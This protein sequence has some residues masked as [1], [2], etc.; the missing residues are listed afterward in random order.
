MSVTFETAAS[1]VRDALTDA[2]RGLVEREAMVELVALSAVA[3]EHL[4]VIGPPGTAKSEAVRRTARALG[5][6]YFEYLLGRFTEPSE[7]FGPVDLRKL[8]E[9]LVETETSGMLPEAEVAF[10]DEVFLGSTAI[11]NTLL[12]IL[13]ERTFRRGHTRMRC[14][15]RVCVGA[16]NALP[17]DDSLAA[18]ADRFL[19]RIFVEPVPDPRLEELLAGGA[20]LWGEGEARATSLESLDVLA[21]VAREA[22][23]ASVRPHLAHALRSLRA[24]GIGLSDRRA[25]K[26]QKLIASAA[27]LAGRRVPSTADL[28]PLVYAV[29]TKEAQALA[30]DVLRELLSA[31]ENPAL[32]AA[33]LEASAGPLARAQRIASAGEVLLSERPAEGNAEALAAW[34]LKLEGVAREMD[35]GFAPESLPEALKAL[36]ARLSEVL[37]PGAPEAPANVA[38]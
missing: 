5:G 6:S 35:A 2:G 15:L 8:R 4:L 23:L 24:A 17:E 36:R 22:D 28:W 11:L 29:P 19:T 14:P 25:V 10:L 7:L 33:A 38:A 9:G 1:A 13:N 20:S 30:R 27:A 26:V 37:S 21:Q 18:F 34:R 12:G 3:G 16:S 31:S 32:A